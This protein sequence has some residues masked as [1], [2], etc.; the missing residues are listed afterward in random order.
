MFAIA[1]IVWGFVVNIGR[2]REGGDVDGR[3][4]IVTAA[5]EVEG[6]YSDA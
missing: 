2:G 1:Y 5:L 3:F 6:V 4:M